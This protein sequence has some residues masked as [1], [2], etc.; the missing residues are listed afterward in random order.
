MI[1]FIG[2]KTKTVQ[3]K[4]VNKPLIVVLE[5][6]AVSLDGVVVNG[7]FT[8][9]RE[10]FTGSEVTVSGEQLKEIG[11]SNLLSSLS[12]FN[13]SLRL[14]EELEY[15]SDPNHIPEMTACKTVNFNGFGGY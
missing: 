10:S 13:P 15:G 8:K 6:D 12:V 4:D 1:S 3:V 11:A 9:K 14:T 5:E 2:M 7:Y